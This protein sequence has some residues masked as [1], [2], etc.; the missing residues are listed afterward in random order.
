MVFFLAGNAAE[1]ELRPPGI[2]QST[3]SYVSI[4]G[5]V[6]WLLASSLSSSSYLNLSITEQ[7]SSSQDD[8]LQEDDEPS[9]S[10]G[11]MILH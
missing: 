7:P 8:E 1:N 5:R 4:V 11:G 6:T 9:A 10:E 3:E 2:R